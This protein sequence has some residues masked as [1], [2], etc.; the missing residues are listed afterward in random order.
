V[1]ARPTFSTVI[2][3]RTSERLPVYPNGRLLIESQT[4]R[5]SLCI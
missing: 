2:N 1:S 5:S 4:N 3:V